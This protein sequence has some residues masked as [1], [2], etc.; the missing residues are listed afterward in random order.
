MQ[1]MVLRHAGA[2]LVLEDRPDPSLPPIRSDCGSRL[3]QSVARICTLSTVNCLIQ[4]FRLYRGTKSSGLSTRSAVVFQ[5]SQQARGLESHGSA[6]LAV[7]VAIAWR[8]GK[9]FVTV[10]SSLATRA[11]A[12]LLLM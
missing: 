5:P 12:V 3:V 2:P 11:M 8:V 10:R 1:A 4:S 7:S 6:I 9:I